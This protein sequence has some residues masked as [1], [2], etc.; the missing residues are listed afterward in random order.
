MTQLKSLHSLSATEALA[1]LKDG[2]LTVTAY[3]TSLLER[4]RE[5]N[6][7]VKAWAYLDPELVLAQAAMLDDLLPE[8]RGPLHGLPI[9][10]KDVFLTKG[11][12]LH[13]LPN[14]RNIWNSC[15]LTV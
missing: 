9:A 11:R 7:V 15:E 8:Q 14:N 13:R 2:R 10:V 12:L 6:P 5:R 4:I 3:A 1:L